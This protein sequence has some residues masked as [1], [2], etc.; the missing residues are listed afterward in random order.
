[1]SGEKD[2]KTLNFDTWAQGYD[3]A[4]AGPAIPSSTTRNMTGCSTSGQRA[5]GVLSSLHHAPIAWYLAL[6]AQSIM[7]HACPSA[8]GPGLTKPLLALHTSWTSP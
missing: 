8:L 6:A 1:M 7:N 2:Y 4:V 3:Q 5:P